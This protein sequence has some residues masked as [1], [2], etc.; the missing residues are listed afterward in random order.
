MS[1]QNKIS[2][3][4]DLTPTNR[5]LRCRVA[6]GFVLLSAPTVVSDRARSPD[7]RFSSDQ[8]EL[9]C[10]RV[11]SHAGPVGQGEGVSFLSFSCCVNHFGAGRTFRCCSDKTDK[12][13]LVTAAVSIEL[14]LLSRG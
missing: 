8:V 11:P 5:G 9:G 10:V 2:R 14:M 6:V 3:K 13:S 7:L 12:S 1:C 4:S